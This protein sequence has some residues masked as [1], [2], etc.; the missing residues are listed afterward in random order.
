M[1]HTHDHID[2]ALLSPE[3]RAQMELLNRLVQDPERPA[4]IGREG[5]RIELPNAVF[6]HLVRVVRMM[7]EGKVIVLYPEKECLTTQAAA[8]LLGVSRPFLVGLLDQG[9]IPHHLVGSH[10]KVYFKDVKA[11]QEN[12]DKE[13][14]AAMEQVFGEID[15]AGVYDKT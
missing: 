11:Y 12:R 14:R 10:R 6:H 8:N 5:V 9:K 13:R 3:E 4:L 7:R 1:K 2:P 15:Q